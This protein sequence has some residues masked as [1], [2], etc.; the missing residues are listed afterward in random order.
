MKEGWNFTPD[1]RDR[2][3]EPKEKL[4]SPERRNFLGALAALGGTAA[5]SGSIL[6]NLEKISEKP[7]LTES[8]KAMRER[9]LDSAV[10]TVGENVRSRN[11]RD[12]LNGKG[13]DALVRVIHALEFPILPEHLLGTSYDAEPI[14]E[15]YQTQIGLYR[16][17]GKELSLADRAS[18]RSVHSHSSAE[19]LSPTEG[20][21][22]NG[23]FWEDRHTLLTAGHVVGLLHPEKPEY[24]Q[25]TVDI[26]LLRVNKR[27]A[28]DSLAKVLTHNNVLPNEKIHGAFASIVG[29]DPDATSNTEGRKI[30][31]GIAIKLTKSMA[32]EILHAA[33]LPNDDV[34]SKRFEHSFMLVLPP[35]ESKL[36]SETKLRP[37]MGMSGSSVFVK[38]G[39][40]FGFGGIFWGAIQIQVGNKSVDIGFFHGG[41]EILEATK[42]IKVDFI[43]ER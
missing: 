33:N 8:D 13:P 40:G 36:D 11:I 4:I 35:G 30:Y 22:G 27:L 2:L 29:I 25:L 9:L 20:A 24:D 21:Y 3:T 6:K 1:K 39:E 43:P 14:S 28:A 19:F 12:A 10:K 32:K 38:N 7:T 5:I 34:S 41:D 16:N 31:P 17:I 26:G 37:A 18:I 15:K 23:V 42:K